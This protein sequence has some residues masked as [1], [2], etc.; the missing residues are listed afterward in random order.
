MNSR[1]FYDAPSRII[2]IKT[3]VNRWDLI[4]LK[5]SGTAKEIINKMKRQPSEWEVQL[6]RD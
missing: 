6:K 1:I 3:K 2:K 5:S 4:K